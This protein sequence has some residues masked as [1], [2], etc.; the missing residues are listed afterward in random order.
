MK[1]LLCYYSLSF[2]F[3]FFMSCVKER[4]FDYVNEEKDRLLLLDDYPPGDI[5]TSSNKLHLEEGPPFPIFVGDNLILVANFDLQPQDSLPTAQEVEFQITRQGKSFIYAIND[6]IGF[7]I[8][9]SNTGHSFSL[10]T[11]MYVPGIWDIR[12]VGRFYIGGEYS[13]IISNTI[14]V[15]VMYPHIDD[16]I[17][18]FGVSYGL[19]NAW[20]E[21]LNDASSFGRNE[22]YGWIFL[23]TAYQ[24]L[25][26]DIE[27]STAGPVV[28]CSSVGSSSFNPP[29]DEVP[30]DAWTGGRFAVAYYH[31]HTPF[32]YCCGITVDHRD[33]GPS[34][35]DTLFVGNYP[36]IVVDYQ[37]GPIYPCHPLNMTFKFYP[38]GPT[39]R[40]PPIFSFDI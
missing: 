29:N 8:S 40:F 22:R 17:N 9:T 10:E 25:Q 4:S 6:S 1:K 28:Q 23:N 37:D 7:K 14:K 11:N 26:Y 39:R 3:L 30:E 31:T 21:T 32:T 20:N 2:L 33:V 24:S 19:E 36:E 13:Y 5:D 27:P 35:Q 18:D 12:A 15:T 38:Y 34:A 16:I